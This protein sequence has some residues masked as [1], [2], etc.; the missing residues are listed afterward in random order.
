MQTD[1]AAA[2]LQAAVLA[3]LAAEGLTLEAPWSEIERCLAQTVS[4]T[5]CVK[6]A[7]EILEGKDN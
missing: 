4:H 2:K 3:K 1:T 6:A 7:R 5:A